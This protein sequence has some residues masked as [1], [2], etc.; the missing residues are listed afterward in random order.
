MHKDGQTVLA[1]FQIPRLK[2]STTPQLRR[3]SIHDKHSGYCHIVGLHYSISHERMMVSALA[4]FLPVMA[5][6]PN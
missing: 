4:V 6:R 3:C 2:I 1:S 5:T